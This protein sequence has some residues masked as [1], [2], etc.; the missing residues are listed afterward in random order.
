MN[1]VPSVLLDSAS[2]RIRHLFSGI[3]PLKGFDEAKRRMLGALTPSR[4]DYR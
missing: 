3:I 1:Q 2:L 4:D